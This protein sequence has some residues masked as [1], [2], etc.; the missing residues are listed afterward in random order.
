MDELDELEIKT[1]KGNKETILIKCI[2]SVL[3]LD[4]VR[5]NTSILINEEKKAIESMKNYLKQNEDK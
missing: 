1:L 4:E 3:H 5:E 2:N